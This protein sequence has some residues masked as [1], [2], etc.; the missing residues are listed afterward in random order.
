[1][2]RRQSVQCLIKSIDVFAIRMCIKGGLLS[3]LDYLEMSSNLYWRETV[4]Q[5]KRTRKKKQ[6]SFPFSFLSFISFSFRGLRHF[7]LSLQYTERAFLRCSF[8]HST[9]VTIYNCFASQISFFCLSSC[10]FL[11]LNL[12]LSLSV[13]NHRHILQCYIFSLDDLPKK[14]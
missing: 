12:Y 6:H 1:M 11:P 4:E 5:G 3:S 8:V 14:P 9:T 2:D 10:I 7:S 13:R